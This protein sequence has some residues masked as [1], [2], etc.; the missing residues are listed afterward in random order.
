MSLYIKTLF[1]NT[2]L[3]I[4]DGEQSPLFRLELNFRKLTKH[5][6]NSSVVINS[7]VGGSHRQHKRER[8]DGETMRIG[9]M[10]IRCEASEEH[11]QAVKLVFLEKPSSFT[12]LPEAA[13]KQAAGM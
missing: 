11:P 5:G 8:I 4:L 10:L 12:V 1:P 6:H 13:A 2:A 3:V 7:I 9:Q